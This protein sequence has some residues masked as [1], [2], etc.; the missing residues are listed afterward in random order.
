[1]IITD[2]L[3]GSGGNKLPVAGREVPDSSPLDISRLPR[4]K[5]RF[6]KF[7]ANLMS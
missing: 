7:N 3:H 6:P 2:W 5:T 4:E 1:M